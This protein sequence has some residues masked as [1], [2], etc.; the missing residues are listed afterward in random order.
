MPQIPPEYLGLVFYVYNSERDAEEARP[1]WDTGG[2]GFFVG[3]PFADPKNEGVLYAVTAA[4]VVRDQ[5]RVVLR[6]NRKDGGFVNTP[7]A[8]AAWTFHPEGDDIAVAPVDDSAL[9][10]YALPE[11]QFLSP[12]TVQRFAIGVGD[13]TFVV[14]RFINHE[15]SQRNTPAAR[16]GN[17][18][19]MPSEPIPNRR[20]GQ[21]HPAYLIETRSQSGYSGA[22]VFVY[23][24]AGAQ[25]WVGSENCGSFMSNQGPWLLGL[26]WGYT[27]VR[28][29]ANELGQL[30]TFQTG[31]SAVVPVSR[32]VELL[33][34]EPLAA[35]RRATEAQRRREPTR[36]SS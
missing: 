3:V 19:M 33:A 32:L 26:L 27:Q 4:H 24:A 22:P 5:P 10:V 7:V 13:E 17:I 18:A 2:T 12:E 16:F 8:F 23:L 30:Q 25:R 29:T 35:L 14:G 31:L 11:S 9:D 28:G 1:Q 15:G 21:A 36:P 34:S 20:T 6:V